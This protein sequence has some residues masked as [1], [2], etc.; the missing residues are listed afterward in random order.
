M[1]R[2]ALRGLLNTGILLAILLVALIAF[3][4]TAP[5]KRMLA[6]ELSSFLSTAESTI[7]IEG[8]QGWLPIDMRLDRLRLADQDGVWLE[9][10]DI[11]ADW[12]P[13]SLFKG[14]IQ[15]DRLRADQIRLA[16]IPEGSEDLEEPSEEPFKLPELPT[17]FHQSPSQN[18]RSRKST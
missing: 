5:G 14:R 9:A 17:S 4:Q 16:R 12:S 1:I 11:V 8:L 2:H 3:V 18:W 7:E 6:A 13:T 10:T 15:I